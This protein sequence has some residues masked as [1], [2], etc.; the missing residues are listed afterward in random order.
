MEKKS[1]LIKECIEILAKPN[2]STW[3]DKNL[4][5]TPQY[6]TINLLEKA[7]KEN[8]LSIKEALAI[9]L[10]VGFQWNVKFEGVP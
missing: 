8:Q 7:I 1:E 3:Y 10:I 2:I 4:K 9:C 5:G 6:Q